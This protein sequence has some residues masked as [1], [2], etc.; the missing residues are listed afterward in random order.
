VFENDQLAELETP[1]EN[2][3]LVGLEGVFQVEFT[4][5]PKILCELF[6]VRKLEMVPEMNAVSEVD[7]LPGAPEPVSNVCDSEK[8]WAASELEEDMLELG[9][10]NVA[11]VRPDAVLFHKLDI[12]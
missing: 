2:V 4:V 5:A 11:T 9:V 12:V 1:A 3:A 7:M 8:D 6:V 10:K